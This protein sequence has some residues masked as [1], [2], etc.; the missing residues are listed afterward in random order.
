MKFR[1]T[2]KFMVQNPSTFFLC[3]LICWIFF[4]ALHTLTD[5]PFIYGTLPDVDEEVE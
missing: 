1:K 5:D 3:Y 4:S 2:L